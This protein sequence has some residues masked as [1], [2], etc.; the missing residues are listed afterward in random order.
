M[1]GRKTEALA[2]PCSFIILPYKLSANNKKAS[3]R[4]RPEDVERAE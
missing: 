4:L 3:L 2:M 1:V